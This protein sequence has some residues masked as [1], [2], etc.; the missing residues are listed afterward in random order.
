[1]KKFYET[2]FSQIY[3]NCVYCEKVRRN[4]HFSLIYKLCSKMSLFFILDF[5]K[6]EFC[7]KLDILKIEFYSQNMHRTR[8]C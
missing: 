1:M 8:H 4:G 5:N 6:I 3:M 7:V 2:I